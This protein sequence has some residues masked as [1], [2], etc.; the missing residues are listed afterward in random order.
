MRDAGQGWRYGRSTLASIVEQAVWQRGPTPALGWHFHDEAQVMMVRS[1]R[2]RIET[3]HG[4]IVVDAGCGLILPPGLPHRSP[5]ESSGVDCHNL[6]VRCDLPF[7]V[8]RPLV[9]RAPEDIC[10]APTEIVLRRLIAAVP[11]GMGGPAINSISPAASV[12]ATAFAKGLARE[13]YIRAFRRS[14]GVT[15]HA[16]R[17]AAMLNDARSLLRAQVP[18]AETAAAAGFADQSHLG[19]VF[20][21]A[22]GITPAAYRSGF[23]A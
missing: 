23:I 6:Y 2:R 21:R 18:P 20:R 19:R 14:V 13:T 8:G 16:Y 3:A 11:T 10:A 4:L 15:P 12:T 1:G 17:L 5:A 7:G 22:F 9:F